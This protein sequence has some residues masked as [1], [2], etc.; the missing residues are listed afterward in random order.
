MPPHHLFTFLNRTTTNPPHPSTSAPPLIAP[1]PNPPHPPTSTRPLI[2]PPPNP[3]PNQSRVTPLA[4]PHRLVPSTPHH[5][6][7]RHMQPMM[8]E[9]GR[10]D[11]VAFIFFLFVVLVVGEYRF[12][13]SPSYFPPWL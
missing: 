12:Y 8:F 10:N 13:A 5:V 11:I 4:S 9:V 3:D 1:P 6:Q 7:Y 2:A